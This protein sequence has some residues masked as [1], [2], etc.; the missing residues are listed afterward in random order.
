MRFNKLVKIANSMLKKADKNSPAVLAGIAIVGVIGT[1]IAAYKAGIKAD[2]ILEDYKKDL[3]YIKKDDKE[4]EKDAKKE[5]AR[6]MIPVVLPPVIMG[7]ITVAS[8][9]GSNK[10]SN[11]RLAIVSA[12]YQF[13]EKKIDELNEKIVEV[14][15]KK[16]AAA[17][18]E[19]V[20]KKHIDDHP[21]R[22]TDMIITGD[23]D[24]ICYDSFND[25]YFRSNAQKI[26][27]AVLDASMMVLGE[28]SITINDF[29]YCLGLKPTPQGDNVGW[30]IDDLEDNKLPISIIAHLTDD[31]R[32]CLAIEYS[33]HIIKDWYGDFKCY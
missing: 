11:K 9:L 14:V 33:T 24:V 4:A 8:I 3:E 19:K 28:Q 10:I 15:G 2:K 30:N 17:I 7:G 22:E 31:E 13:S 27:K 12:A 1:A 6:K 21:P 5:T 18:K 20:S 16:K 25:R 32:P 29:Y 23:G 26:Q